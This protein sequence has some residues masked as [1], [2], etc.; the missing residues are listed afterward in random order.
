MLFGSLQVLFR[1][2]FVG[3]VLLQ[4]MAA[5]QC[6]AFESMFFIGIVPRVK[7]RTLEQI[8]FLQW[9]PAFHEFRRNLATVHQVASF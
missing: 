8:E 3:K 6:L 5:F 7:I 4:W 9:L 1:C 2:A